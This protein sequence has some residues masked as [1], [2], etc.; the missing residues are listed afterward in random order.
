MMRP[1]DES[2]RRVDEHMFGHT[3]PAEVF[4]RDALHLAKERQDR[5]HAALDLWIADAIAE[6]ATGR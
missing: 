4:D 1:T 2:P 6:L 5:I 3:T